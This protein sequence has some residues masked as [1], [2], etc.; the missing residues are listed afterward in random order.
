MAAMILPRFAFFAVLVLPLV[1]SG[2]GRAAAIDPLLPPDT[3]SYLSINVKTLRDSELFK[4]QLLG[5]FKDLLGESAEAKDVLN[6]LGFDPTK[7]LDRVVFAMPGG[8]DT[9]RG[10]IIVD[11]TFDEASFKKRGEEAARDNDANLKI[12]K[13]KLGKDLT[14]TVWEVIIPGQDASLFVTLASGKRMLASPGKDYVVDALKLHQAKKKT[15][16]KNKAIAALIDKLDARQT[17][18]I[19]VLGKSIADAGED[20][21][22]KVAT[23]ALRQVEAIGGGLTVG[24]EVKLSLLIAGKDERAATGVREGLDRGIKLGL[25][26]L[27]LLA[28]GRKE[29]SLLLEV[30]KTL[31]VSG[32]GAVVSIS[33]KLTADVLEDFFKKDE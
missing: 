12:H 27:A 3:E 33:G 15:T 6:D 4:K 30:V 10:L 31:K 18:S 24:N 19:A 16:L 13:V 32:K 17:V 5:P 21:L 1:A 9:D 11:G 28:E 14:H 20:V 23:N 29:L 8:T 25:V 2:T 22:P 26:G 7:D